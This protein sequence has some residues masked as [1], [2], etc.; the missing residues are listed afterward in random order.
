MNTLVDMQSLIRVDRS[1]NITKITK[2][3]LNEKLDEF[4]LRN[5]YRI[6]EVNENSD[7]FLD[8]IRRFFRKKKSNNTIVWTKFVQVTNF[9]EVKDFSEGVRQP[10]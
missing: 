5:S 4:I 2:I 6:V 10:W 8:K 3:G 9:L 1:K 7:M